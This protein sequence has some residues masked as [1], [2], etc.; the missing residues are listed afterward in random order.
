MSWLI[1]VLDFRESGFSLLL[2][3]GWKNEDVALEVNF[4]F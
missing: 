2:W 4:R 3:S 1:G